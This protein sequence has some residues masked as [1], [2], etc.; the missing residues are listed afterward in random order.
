[1]DAFHSIHDAE[2]LQKIFI[3]Q[4]TVPDVEVQGAAITC[5]G[6]LA[7]LH[8]RID[9]DSLIGPFQRIF[10]DQPVLRGRLNDVVD[11]LQVF[12]GVDISQR[13]LSNK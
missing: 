13:L 6:H 12:L 11:D 8:R 1:V 7:R 5:L 10:A 2:W 9:V 3:K 4:L